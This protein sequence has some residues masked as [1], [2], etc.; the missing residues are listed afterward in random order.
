[1]NEVATDAN[2]LK[3][4]MAE[5]KAREL[6]SSKPARGGGCWLTDKGRKRAEK[7]RSR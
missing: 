2:S 6:V 1:M 3:T 4:V 5:L 7:L